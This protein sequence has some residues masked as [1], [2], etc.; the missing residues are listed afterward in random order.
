LYS[1]PAD[2]AA[3]GDR[4]R[5][6][7][8]EQRGRDRALDHVTGNDD[9][10]DALFRE[11]GDPL[12]QRVF[13]GALGQGDRLVLGHRRCRAD[14]VGLVARDEDHPRAVVQQGQRGVEDSQLGVAVED[15]RIVGAHPA[16]HAAGRVE[17]EQ[18]ESSERP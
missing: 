11:G 2:L 3:I 18:I 12:A 8:L 14:E 13:T 6:G 10:V 7:A 15:E 16:L 17:D 9:E 4:A 1:L 5:V